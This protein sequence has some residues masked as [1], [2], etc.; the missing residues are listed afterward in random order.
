MEKKQSF[1]NQSQDFKSWQ[2]AF[3]ESL[4]SGK[5]QYLKKNISDFLQVKLK[6]NCMLWKD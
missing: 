1:Q 2:T 5:S 6:I 3:C 4:W